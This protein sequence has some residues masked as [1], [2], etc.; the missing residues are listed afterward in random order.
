MFTFLMGAAPLFYLFSFHTSQVQSIDINIEDTNPLVQCFTSCGVCVFGCVWEG[1]SVC[2][3]LF[4]C[5]C[6]CLFVC[7]GVRVCVCVCVC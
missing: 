2:V 5:V 1:V 6:V 3:C 4:V 7:V